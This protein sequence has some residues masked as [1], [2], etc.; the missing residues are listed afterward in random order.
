MRV[1]EIAF[2]IGMLVGYIFG[3]FGAKYPEL[4]AKIIIVGLSIIAIAC[5]AGVLSL[6]VMI[7]LLNRKLGKLDKVKR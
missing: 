7:V 3:Y 2:S 5:L 6:F 4:F 1:K